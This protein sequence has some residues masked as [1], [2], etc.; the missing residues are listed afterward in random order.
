MEDKTYFLRKNAAL[1]EA[2]LEAFSMAPYDG[3][4]LND[5][6]RVSGMNKG[7]FY[8]H[9]ADKFDLYLAL[10]N[11]MFVEQKNTINWT[12]HH[13]LKE[14]LMMLFQSLQKLLD[15][16]P[17]FL[18]LNRFLFLECD[19]FYKKVV[20]SSIGSMYEE[21]L[22]KF[23]LQSPLIL[24]SIRHFYTHFDEITQKQEISISEIVNFVFNEP[25][26]VFPTEEQ[27]P[28]VVF[29]LNSISPFPS[30]VAFQIK[31]GETISIIEEMEDK[32]FMNALLASL[33]QFELNQSVIF[34]RMN[35]ELLSKQSAMTEYDCS[36]YP[37]QHRE[38]F[39]KL[40]EL[41]LEGVISHPRRYQSFEEKVIIHLLQI[42]SS[43]PKF[44]V[45]DH[46]L[47]SLSPF[48]KEK[49]LAALLNYRAYETTIILCESNLE[50]THPYCER[51]FFVKDK[52]VRLKLAREQI[53]QMLNQDYRL[54]TYLESGVLMKTKVKSDVL[55]PF[56]VKAL[57]SGMEIHEIVSLKD[58]YQQIQSQIQG[59][60]RL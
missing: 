3:A 26:D 35:I 32:P 49:L 60:I 50:F 40:R 21:F 33:T 28:L 14:A 52:R 45:I 12:Q 27:E 41:G 18:R 54:V 2:S 44:L 51:Y 22:S 24:F 36:R 15:I 11:A 4:S 25:S 1:F 59:G 13:S 38:L 30:D 20:F 48:F 17:R 10:V 55:Q 47:S 7:S 42:L 53:Q 5:I 6:I 57:A 58:N 19:D 8:Y 16:D 9:Y 46:I 34:A 56:L 37:I 31:S 39:T 29:D 23:A 43:S